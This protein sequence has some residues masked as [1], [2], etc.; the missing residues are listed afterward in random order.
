MTLPQKSERGLSLACVRLK[1]IVY[2]LDD[3]GSVMSKPDEK[4]EGEVQ[5]QSE[6]ERTQTRLELMGTVFLSN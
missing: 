1:F 6:Q 4:G 5:A 3:V 2:I